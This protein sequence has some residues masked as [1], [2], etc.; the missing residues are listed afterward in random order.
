[1]W[2]TAWRAIQRRPVRVQAV[3]QSM[4]ALAIGFGLDWSTE[5]MGLVL[6]CSA[7]VLALITETQTAPMADPT[8]A[9][10]VTRRDLLRGAR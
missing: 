10:A 4:V 2:D 3:I 9:A 6:V 5:Q 1:M 8:I 7:S